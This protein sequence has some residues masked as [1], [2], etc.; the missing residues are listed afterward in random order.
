MYNLHIQ[1]GICTFIYNL[2]CISIQVLYRS[3]KGYKINMHE[4]SRQDYYTNQGYIVVEV[5]VLV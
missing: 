5:L 2:P 4:S 3:S 1:L